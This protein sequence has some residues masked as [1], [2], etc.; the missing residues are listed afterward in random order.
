MSGWH[1]QH[2]EKAASE[3]DGNPDVVRSALAIG[4]AVTAVNP[5]LTPVFT[6]RHL[7][8]L[9]EVPYGILRNVVAR[10]IDPYRSFRI[11][12]SVR[13]NI[14]ENYRLISVP[15]FFLM[16]VQRWLA[17]NILAYGRPHHASAAYARESDI[18][19]TASLHCQA[20]WLIKLDIKRFFES[21]SEIAVYRVFRELGYQPL[22]AFELS[23]ICTRLRKT[24]PRNWAPWRSYTQ[25]WPTISAYWSAE[26][27]YLPQGAPTSPMI[28]NLAVRPLDKKIAAISEA[29]GLTYTRY[30]DDLSLSTNRKEFTRAEASCL[31][32]EIYKAMSTHGF[33]PNLTKTHLLPPGARKVVLGL[34]VNGQ[35]PRL[36]REFRA[37]IRM[38]LYYL[39][40]LGPVS[41]QLNRGFVSVR[42]LRNHVEGLI[43][44]ANHID[45][46]FA[47]LCKTKLA[48]IQWPL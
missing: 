27:G 31:I 21:I 44:F 20:K 42:S 37:G 18:K 1:P 43:N 6:L 36:T 23:R 2:F 15:D 40:K 17:Q 32:G 34:L 30:A 28:A 8:H 47:Q 39:E 11:A 13:D 3:T 10:R 16:R 48:R 45:P 22:V 9:T 26:M 14:D 12:K 46:E 19:L 35:I 38:H 4:K 5:D 29:H 7:A 33:S 41:H 25:S 24:L